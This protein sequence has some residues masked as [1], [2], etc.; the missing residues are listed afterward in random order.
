MRHASLLARVGY[1]YALEFVTAV[2][3]D[4][5]LIRNPP[6][7]QNG[8]FTYDTASC[9]FGYALLSAI[10]I[11]RVSFSN[12]L[13]TITYRDSILISLIDVAVLPA[14]NSTQ[15]LFQTI[16]SACGGLP[17]DVVAFVYKNGPLAIAAHFADLLS[18][19]GVRTQLPIAHVS[20]FFVAMSCA[21]L[22]WERPHTLRRELVC[23]LI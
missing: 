8:C 15:P 23:S 6:T 21:F 22:E 7:A 18:R 2:P 16:L 5:L 1:A 12:W 17:F 9:G 10:K 4:S 3:C 11:P 14:V 19:A 20:V 13:S